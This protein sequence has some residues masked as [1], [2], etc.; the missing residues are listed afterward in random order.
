[1]VFEDHSLSLSVAEDDNKIRVCAI[2]ET[3][4]G[5]CPIDS[6]ISVTFN[7][8]NGTAGNCN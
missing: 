2:I 6:I 1:M 3:D 4:F 7:T 8:T 5:D